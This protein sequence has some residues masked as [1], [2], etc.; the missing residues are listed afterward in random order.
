MSIMNGSKPAKVWKSFDEQLAHL[1]NKGLLIIDKSRALHSLKY[2]GYY[3]LSGYW[4]GF[5]VIDTAQSNE[6]N[7]AVRYDHFMPNSDFDTVIALYSFDKKLRLLAL[8]A[9]ER[10]EMAMRTD[11]AY[12]LGEKDPYAYLNTAYLHPN[13]TK[14]SIQKGKDKGK[15]AYQVWLDKYQTLLNRA[16]KLPFVAHHLEHYGQLP[17]WVAVEILDFGALSHLFAGM[18]F[19]DKQAIAQKYHTEGKTLE[20][21]LKSLNFI[22]NVSAHHSRLWNANILDLSP[23]NAAWQTPN[24]KAYFYFCIMQQ[25]L[26]VISPS[27]TW[28]ER[29]GQLLTEFPEMKNRAYSLADFGLPSQWQSNPIWQK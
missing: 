8:D 12:V 18:A 5:R 6:Q 27:S 20:K 16:K 17:I 11:V 15:T 1:Q 4:Y 28:G 23:A 26:K 22:R 2:L 13:F 19:K 9:L 21:W 10:I 3:R 29:F 25:M 14:K 24:Q 7:K